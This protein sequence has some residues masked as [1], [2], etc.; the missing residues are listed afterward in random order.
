M[1]GRPGGKSGRGAPGPGELG[2]RLL[3]GAALILLV[4]FALQRSRDFGLGAR[5][6][7]A[8]S[9]GTLRL[10]GLAG[11]VEILRDAR[12]IPHVYAA[13]EPELWFGVGFA[14]AEDRLAQMITLRRRA[15]GR[16]A[17]LE[18]ESALAADRLARLLEIEPVS[19][20]ASEN[21]PTSSRAVLESYAAGVN[22]RIA[23]IRD[24]RA[25]A[26]SQL[27]EL[28]ADVEPWRPADSLA[29][30]KLLAWCMG[31]TLETTLVLDELIQRLDSVPARPFFPGRASVDFGVAPSLP[32][33]RSFESG[34]ARSHGPELALGS[35]QSLCRGIGQPTGG[36]WIVGSG[37]SASGMPLVVADWQLAPSTP[38]L[39]HELQVSG[40]GIDVLGATVPGSPI[41][42][43]GRT[44]RLA[45][46]GLPAG[47][48]IADLFIETL[49]EEPGFYQNGRRRERL[50]ERTE[51]IRWVDS[52]GTLREETRVLRSTR[53]GPLIEWLAGGDGALASVADGGARET[54][55]RS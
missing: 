23:R 22:A 3:A 41:F 10:A 8:E 53:H 43:I 25:T 19:R 33:L 13:R 40:G 51:T 17:E 14:H 27:G 30:V 42:W 39:F 55:A 48:P 9:S 44:P 37:A 11:A 47:A 16:A 2:L 45:W 52:G 24:D 49:A 20:S 12:G 1:A 7:L 50:A 4:L 6:A 31:G 15:Y 54:T 21:L 35:T 36:A 29:V 38:A 26:P 5:S 34:A 18:G 32:M 46:A 28:I